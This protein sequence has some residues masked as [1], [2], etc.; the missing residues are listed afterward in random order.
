MMCCHGGVPS[1]RGPVVVFAHSAGPFW[2]SRRK[3]STQDIAHP[4]PSAYLRFWQV[5]TEFE[6]I[7]VRDYLD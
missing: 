7:I 6:A 4:M 3:F 2:A 1:R 5:S